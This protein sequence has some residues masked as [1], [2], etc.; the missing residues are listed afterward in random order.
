[1][2]TRSP[3]L[4]LLLPALNE[5]VGAWN[6]PVN[7]NFETMDDWLSDLYES[8]VGSSA[9]GTWGDLRGS[10]A[11]LS[12]R[13]AVSINPDGTINTAGSPE[14][15]ALATSV[16]DGVFSSPS[17]RFDA[18]SFEAYSTRAPF[19]ASRFSVTAPVGFPR[20]K[21]EDGDAW[22][23]RDFGIDASHPIASPAKP[24]APGCVSGLDT[25]LV[26]SAT[27]TVDL[28]SGSTPAIFDIDGYL[29]RTR[30]Q[31][32]LDFSAISG[33]T[34][35]DYIWIFV[36][37]DSTRYNTATYHYAGPT[38]TPAAKDLR[39]L[40]SGSVGITSASSFTDASA[41]FSSG[42][43]GTLLG[44]VKS[45]DVL[46]ITNTAAAGS[47]V[48]DAVGS[49]TGLTIRGKFKAD[50]GS[51][52]WYIY[53]EAH[54]N[55]GAVRTALATDLPPFI[56]GRAYIGRVQHHAGVN[57]D[58]V[59]TFARGGVYDSGWNATTAAGIVGTPLVL[60]HNLGARPTQV[61]IFFRANAA[62][63]VYP[64]IVERLVQ[65]DP[66]PA[67][68]TFLVPSVRWHATDVAIT[69]RL[70]NLSTTPAK[71]S[72]LFTDSAGTDVTSGD[73][74]VVARR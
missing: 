57:P 11:S 36:E 20:A 54:P 45:G 28:M 50:V 72:A 41:H 26:A 27:A 43:T 44:K 16:T 49:D 70:K 12:A 42:P 14:V 51:V 1:M 68:A 23:S 24:Y 9:T 10:L 33:L 47:Y 64:P 18:D 48:V 66:G 13:L 67:T 62:G 3:F 61:D 19:V 4:K 73:I 71:A 69:V 60:N 17:D 65:T 53:D 31:I 35:G 59:V 21:L 8:L 58:N 56:A 38:G 74:R 40:Q 46:V 29:F 22:R 30:E 37:R 15:V 63:N 52:A 55:L 32:S 5:F 7:N 39:R 34:D 2:A 25:L 6:E